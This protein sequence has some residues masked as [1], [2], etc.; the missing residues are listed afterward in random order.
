MKNK[1]V[2]TLVALLT[3]AILVVS[4][5]GFFAAMKVSDK[6]RN[7]VT[8][9]FSAWNEDKNTNATPEDSLKEGEKSNGIEQVYANVIDARQVLENLEHCKCTGF[10][11]VYC[12]RRADRWKTI[13]N[14][15]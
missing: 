3:V 8:G 15:F 6:F 5:T 10:T 12:F 11:W 7:T 4:M 14:I 13:F 1:K 2:G 9:Y